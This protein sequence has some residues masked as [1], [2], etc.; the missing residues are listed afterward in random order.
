[1]ETNP[2]FDDVEVTERPQNATKS[3]EITQVIKGT[4]QEIYDLEDDEELEYGEMD[5]ELVQV[6]GEVEHKGTK[7]QVQDSMAFYESP[8]TNSAFGK[9]LNRYGKPEK[10]LKVDWTFDDNGRAKIV[11]IRQ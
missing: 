3:G 10:G 11:G 1:M 7:V 6:L 4:R 9:F 2:S 5:D 8:T